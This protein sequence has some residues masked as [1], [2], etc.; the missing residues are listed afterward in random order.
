MVNFDICEGSINAE[1]ACKFWDNIWCVRI[2]T[3]EPSDR[4]KPNINFQQSVSSLPK[5]VLSVVQ[6]TGDVMR[7]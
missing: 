3:T 6:S 2:Q 1:G 4:V 5:H 7:L